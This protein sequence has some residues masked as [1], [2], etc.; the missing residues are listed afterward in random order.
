VTVRQGERA[1]WFAKRALDVLLS[2]LALILLLPLLA[3]IAVLIKLDD[4]DAAVLFRQTRTGLAGRRFELLKFRT[5]L[6]QAEALK[7]Q[8]RSLSSVS[9]PDFRLDGDPRVTR[10]GRFLRKTS[11]DELPQLVNVLRGDMTL[12]GPRPTSFDSSTYALWQ[13]E[14]L[15]FRP[16]LTG[17]WQVWGRDRMDF[18]ERCRLDIA[19]FRRRSILAELGLLALTVLVLFRRTGSA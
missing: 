15:E 2:G 9:W 3:V 17:P 18:D 4:G 12:V 8:L 19:F 10:L 7:E 1:Y 16:G 6:P 5:M 11:L 13:T 14:R